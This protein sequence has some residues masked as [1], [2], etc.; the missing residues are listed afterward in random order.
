MSA[1]AAPNATAPSA[2]TTPHAWRVIVSASIG[3]ALEWFDLVVYGFF[4]VTIAKLFFPTGN[5]TVSLLLTLGTFGVSFFMR[6]LGAIVIGAYADRAGRKAALTLSILLMMVG[7]LLIALMPTYTSIG[8][9]A[10]VG[11]VI[12]R[13]V[14]GFSA[15]GEFGS[16]TAFLAEHAPQ[17]RGFF[18]SWQVASQG[19]TTLL[20]A[21]FGALL[22]GN[23]SP[24]AM[25][26][27]GWRVPFFFGLLIGPVAY[28]IRRR[29]DE[30]PEFLDIEP[31]QNP[32]RD[33]FASQK[34]RLLLAIGVVVMAT[35]ATYLVLYMP[36]YAVK[37]LGLPSS[38]A[39]SA[40]LLT[41][42]VQLIV[43][44]IVGHWS[45]THG[46]IK[47]MLAAAVALLVLVYPMFRFLDAN[48][49][50]GSLMVFQI[51][52]GL[53]MTTY[54][55]ALPALL[56]ELFPTQVR[57]TGLSL[58]YNIAATVFGGFA[59]FIITWL[60]GATGNKLAPSFYLIFAAVISI[61]ALLR[62]RKLG[63]R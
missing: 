40:V 16:A 14:Q 39:F 7:T 29:L 45:D 22:T 25:A 13:M 37:Q 24:E 50:F 49:T 44:P 53:L 12:A 35:V 48:P 1:S 43:A 57:T 15:G 61:T 51:V 23:L 55:G 3:N 52:L 20:A 8:V 27:W 6:P 4:A 62:S 32:L 58:S 28:Y 63:L 31:T 42:V 19:L 2:R 46:R 38:A 5:D 9:L 26:S 18:S 56:T 54:F 30:T 17:R 11:I 60:I 36:T 10:P 21:G 59:P 34:E 33:T 41:G 47:P